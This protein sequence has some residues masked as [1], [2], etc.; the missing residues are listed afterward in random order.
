MR[1][2]QK[3]L[4]WGRRKIFD[5]CPFRVCS[6]QDQLL[7]MSLLCVSELLCLLFHLLPRFMINKNQITQIYLDLHY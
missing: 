2:I 5:D 6:L 4:H 1:S 7:M 3:E